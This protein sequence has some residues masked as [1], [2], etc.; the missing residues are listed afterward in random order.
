MSHLLALR[1]TMCLGVAL[2]TLAG[3]AAA[4][5]PAPARPKQVAPAQ[6]TAP[7]K[8][9]GPSIVNFLKVRTP[10]GVQLGA[11]GAVYCIDWPDGVNQ[12]YRR[13]N[14]ADPKAPMKRITDFKDG[15]SSYAL[16]FDNRWAT[17]SAA[18][19]GNENTNVWLLNAADDSIVPVLQNKDVQF[20]VQLWL[21]D[22]SGFVYRANDTSPKDFHL[23]RYDIASKQSTKVLAKEGDWSAG[24]IA[25]DL[26]RMLVVNY[27]SASDSRVFELDIKTGTLRDLSATAEGTES[28]NFP[29]GYLP[30][31]KQALLQSDV[32]EGKARLYIRDLADAAGKPMK[33]ALPALG[34]WELDGAEIN[35]EK[36]HLA[37]THNE[38]GYSTLRVYTLPAMEE[39]KLPKIEKGL[40]GAGQ[41]RGS[42]LLYTLNNANT[43]TL[44]YALDLTK[45]GEPR[46][47]TTRM[48]SETIDLSTFRLPE[49][50]KYKSFD[51]LEI[52]SF[53]YLPA[54]ARK[55]SPVPFVVNYH[56]GPEGQHR[57]GFDR[58]SQ[59]LVSKGY[60]VLLPNVRGSTGYGRE[61]Q[62]MDNYKKRWDSVKDGVEAAKW[63]VSEGY[64]AKGKIA[65]Y[66][67][68]YGGFMSVACL[69]EGGDIF[70]AGINIV[71]IVNFQ[72]FLQQ[73]AGYR[74]ALREAEYGPLSDPEFLKSVSPLLQIDKIKVPM[75]IAHG[76][77]DPRVPVGEAMQLAVGLQERGYDPELVFFPDEGHGFAKLRNR[78]IFNE[79]LVKFLDAH[80]G[81]K[82]N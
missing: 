51:G 19:G 81:A 54:G 25:S 6:A 77:N 73:T 26:S 75:M 17:L 71:G 35:L 7:A 15:V 82:S 23:Y 47:L 27:R 52:P 49:L 31:E 53:L 13:D 40:Q 39:V 62:M 45:G 69:V 80:I 33:E 64:A 3:A 55:G 18:V 34:K 21:P 5:A 41:F 56:G 14:A 37:V 50:V 32:K 10:T 29:V 72:T 68:S 70:G 61:F 16:S 79:R 59:Y 28:A 20:T 36:T 8:P 4:Q 63:L 11:N 22:S 44:A 67:G 74:R 12:V 2:A 42:T 48:D 66:G 43:P 38:D 78:I 57:P 60:G 58:V 76:L 46:A 1:R 30:G 65:T 9:A 24:D